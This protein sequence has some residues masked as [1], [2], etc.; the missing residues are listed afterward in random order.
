MKTRNI[1]APHITELQSLYSKEDL[2]YPMP[3]KE[4]VSAVLNG[5]RFA[6]FNDFNE[7]CLAETMAIQLSDA[8][9]INAAHM[10]ANLI[11]GKLNIK[12]LKDGKD[13]CIEFKK[14]LLDND[15]AISCDNVNI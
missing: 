7:Y 14:K 3:R 4:L 1:A 13:A 2:V 6:T 12:A 10:I 15:C 9:N 5:Q 8:F 11:I